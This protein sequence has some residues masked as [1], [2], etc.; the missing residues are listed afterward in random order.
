MQGEEKRAFKPVWRRVSGG[1]AENK[2]ET[3]GAG[4]RREQQSRPRDC[5]HRDGLGTPDDWELL[6]IQN[7]HRVCNKDKRGSMF[8]FIAIVS[9]GGR[10]RAIKCAA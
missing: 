9:N 2:L 3:F 6:E 4:R 10:K 5:D 1:Q 8:I 7:T